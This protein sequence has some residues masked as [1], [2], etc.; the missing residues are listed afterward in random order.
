M[1]RTI[2]VGDTVK[3]LSADKSPAIG[4]MKKFIGQSGAVGR[5]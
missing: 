3:I 4:S 1:K 5:D 2:K